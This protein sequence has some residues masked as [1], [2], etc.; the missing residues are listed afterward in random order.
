MGGR[1]GDRTTILKKTWVRRVDGAQRR[2][3]PSREE[4]RLIKEAGSVRIGG[5]V[6]TMGRFQK[7]SEG[8]RRR[9]VLRV[10]LKSAT[11]GA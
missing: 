1:E 2:S 9:K 10:A 7:N 3:D 11:R 4:G 6:E 8:L 5:D